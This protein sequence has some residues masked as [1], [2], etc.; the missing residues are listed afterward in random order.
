LIL[1]FFFFSLMAVALARVEE[2]NQA[3]GGVGAP[4]NFTWLA[5]WSQ[6]KVRWDLSSLAT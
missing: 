6:V 3:K 5:H 2:V 4:F 1:P